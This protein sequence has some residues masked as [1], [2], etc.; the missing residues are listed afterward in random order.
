[1]PR[2]KMTL[3]SWKVSLGEGMTG[4]PSSSSGGYTGSVISSH[5]LGRDFLDLCKDFLI[6]FSTVE[7]SESC[8]KNSP[9]N[10]S[11]SQN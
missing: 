5:Q 8:L 1:M 9:K 6:R 4:P 2:G 10:A 11:N 7:K 3:P